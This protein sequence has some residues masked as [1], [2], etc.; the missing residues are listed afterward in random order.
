[1]NN[2]FR[3]WCFLMS[4]TANFLMSPGEAT[5]QRRRRMP[6][7]RPAASVSTKTTP[8][9]RATKDST[10]GGVVRD[11][12]TAT[13]LGGAKLP[14]QVLLPADYASSERRRYP[15]LYLLHGANGDESDWTTR[16][17]LASYVEH[18][19]LIVV[20]PG[21]GNSWYAN[22]AGDERARYE[23]AIIRDLIPHID[24]RYRT[25]ASAYG[26]GVAGLSMGGFGAMKFALRY[27]HLFAFAA[28]FSGAFDAPRT[29]I[30][31]TSVNEEHSKILLRIFGATGS[32]TR[33]QNDLFQLLGASN[34]GARLPYLYISTGANDT[35]ASVLPANPRFADALRERKAVY[36]YHERPGGHDWHFWDAEIRLALAR[37]SEIV[38]HMRPEKL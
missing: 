1:M 13:S 28:S 9:R 6:Q 29:N 30:V 8:P 33:R 17:N 34:A 26:R 35:L 21:V 10:V 37:M 2:K 4:L 11:A 16:T 36:E 12:L 38:T 27:P 5:A 18:Y 7:Q 23:D 19:R 14:F 32:E 3:A 24:A 20:M 31:S 25:L 15:V 22:S